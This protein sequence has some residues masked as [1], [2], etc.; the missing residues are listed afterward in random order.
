MSTLNVGNITDGTNTV[1]TEKLSKGTAAAWVNF[2]GTGTVSIRGSYNV[3]SITDEGT[4]QYMINFSSELSTS[5]YVALSN[6]GYDDVTYEEPRNSS[7][8]QHSTTSVRVRTG[9]SAFT[10]QDEH[11]VEVAVFCS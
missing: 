11:R 1:D 6:S 8:F 7:C 10:S 2:N 3:S 5:N 4:G 9:Y